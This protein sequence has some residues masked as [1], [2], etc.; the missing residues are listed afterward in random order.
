MPTEKC[1][2]RI[3]HL[4]GVAQAP[5]CGS[6][7]EPG[8]EIWP[9][10]S[11][12]LAPMAR[13]RPQFYLHFRRNWSIPTPF[14]FF[15]AQ[16][17]FSGPRSRVLCC[18]TLLALALSPPRMSHRRPPPATHF[19]STKTAQTFINKLAKNTHFTLLSSS[20]LPPFYTSPWLPGSPRCPAL[21]RAHT[22]VPRQSVIGVTN[23]G[24][25]MLTLAL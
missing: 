7:K 21:C 13:F 3:N 2:L 6:T 11:F 1:R 15:R 19:T 25:P 17:S 4:S 8:R 5:D 10:L 22:V 18:L 20:E 9:R 23:P 16:F 12:F 24:K 14:R